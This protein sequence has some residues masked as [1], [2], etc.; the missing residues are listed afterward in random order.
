MAGQADGLSPGLALRTGCA[1]PPVGRAVTVVA[2]VLESVLAAGVEVPGRCGSMRTA[3][4]LSFAG[5]G[6]AALGSFVARRPT[7]VL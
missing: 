3:L 6:T 2:A 5:A 7:T 4:V 1:A